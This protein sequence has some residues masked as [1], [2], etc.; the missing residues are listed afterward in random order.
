MIANRR[1]NVLSRPDHKIVDRTKVRDG[2]VANRPVYMA[3]AVTAEGHRDILGLWIGDGGEGAKYW[4]QVLTEIKNRGAADVLMLVCDGLTGLPDAVNTVWPA[5]IVQ[6]CVVHLLRNSFRYAARQ[7]W[8]KIAKAL[9]PV[10]TAPT[11]EAALERF[12]EFTDAW[13]GK[14]PAIV[15]L[16]EAAWAEFVPFLQFDVE[17]RKIVCTTNA[18]ESINARIRKAVR[19][20]GH[21]PTDQAALKCVYL[22]V[23]SLDP[24]G[25]GRKRWTI[26]WKA[27]LQAFDITFDGRLTAG[28]R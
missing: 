22:A 6:T 4:L 7:D 1:S 19:A 24:T 18:I 12:V 28:R 11:E 5:T 17:I 9:R 20:R 27:A 3:V 15:R 14:Y 8:E 2:Q 10:Y 21:F 26:R 16:W 13:G 25:T 23:M